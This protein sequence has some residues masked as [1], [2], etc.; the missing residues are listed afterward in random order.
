MIYPR[1]Y[2]PGVHAH[3]PMGIY[4]NPYPHQ[5][6]GYG[7]GYQVD[8]P[9]PIPTHTRTHDPQWVSHT[10]AFAYSKHL[11]I[12]FDVIQPL[13]LAPSCTQ[14]SKSVLAGSLVFCMVCGSSPISP[15]PHMPPQ[16]PVVVGLKQEAYQVIYHIWT[17]SA[18]YLFI[19]PELYCNFQFS[20]TKIS[21]LKL[22]QMGNC[23]RHL[24]G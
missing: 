6:Y 11:N 1:I 20:K 22:V 4:P 5:G 3:G 13:S 8:R 2:P 24:V 17:I 21:K 7:L 16:L 18:I 14:P 10:H 19:A 12:I 15:V 9:L 23:T